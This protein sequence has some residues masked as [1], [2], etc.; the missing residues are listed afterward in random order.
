[1]QLFDLTCCLLACAA[2][3][4]SLSRSSPTCPRRLTHDRIWKDKYTPGH[5][6][7]KTARRAGKLD[8]KERKKREKEDAKEVKEQERREKKDKEKEAKER[9]AVK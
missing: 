1:M 9:Q 5:V 2:L 7:S 3:S 6:D 4:P 8:E